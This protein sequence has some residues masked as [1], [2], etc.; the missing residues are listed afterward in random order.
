M[1][2][3]PTRPTP[4]KCEITKDQAKL[5]SDTRVALSW[6]CPAFMH[7]FLTLLDNGDP[8]YGALFT[9]DVPIAGTDGSA[10]MLN[11]DEFFKFDLQERVFIIA[12]E[13]LHCI[14]N[15]MVSLHNWRTTKKVGYP[16]GKVL[17]YDHQI[18]NI[19]LDLVI[20]DI[21][22]DAK[23]G[24]FNKKWLHDT[25]IA[26]KAD[27]GVDVYRKLFKEAEQRR[28]G[29]G[30]NQ[31]PKPGN[32]PPQPGNQLAPEGFD[33]HLAPGTS[34]GKNPHQAVKDR[35][36][37]KWQTE[38]AAAAN[39]QRLQ[40]KMPAGLERIFQEILTPQVDWKDKIQALF[41]RKLGAGSYDWYKPDDE[42]IVRD[43]FVPARS[44]FG[45]GTVVV[46]VDTSG[47]IT[48]KEVDMFLAEVAGI[49]EDVR[50]RELFICWCDA[51][52]HR[53]DE[54]YEPSDLNEIRAKGAPGGGGTDFRPVFDWIAERGLKPDALVYLTDGHGELPGNKP[55]Y[56]VI[57]ASID[58]KSFPWGDTVMV[59]K[60]FV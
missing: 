32:Q 48:S 33:E 50:P 15:H 42:F 28:K 14:L 34:E 7:I 10:L 52:L 41:A 16:D 47:S 4:E 56:D 11:P 43:I 23:V 53:T 59:P 40:G 46:S 58:R 27:A 26:T 37:V 44:G 21:L 35:N 39:I 18:M 36:D 3:R 51:T 1:M 13:I 45:A 8:K 2:P 5:W 12:H 31:P 30:G 60:Q 55:E 54:C 29:P 19:S 49:L 9:R 22:V 20:N 6:H 38:I 24:K 57:W 25:S 17:P